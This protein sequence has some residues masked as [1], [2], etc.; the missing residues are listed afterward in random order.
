VKTLPETVKFKIPK[1]ENPFGECSNQKTEIAKT[2]VIQI[3]GKQ[4]EVCRSCW[5]EIVKNDDYQWTSPE[6]PVEF[7]SKDFFTPEWPVFRS[8]NTDGVC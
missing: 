3:G 5:G 1:C 4:Y 6:A 7:M 2:I 8:N